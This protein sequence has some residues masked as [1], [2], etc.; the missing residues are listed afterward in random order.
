MSSPK[1]GA[2][3]ITNR[4]R[5]SNGKELVVTFNGENQPMT[6][7][8]QQEDDSKQIVSGSPM[9]YRNTQSFFVLQVGD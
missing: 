9:T 7:E 5:D 3:Y 6:V 1:D 8:P 2:Y 4:V